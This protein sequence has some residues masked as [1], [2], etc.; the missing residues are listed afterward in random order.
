MQIL[1]YPYNRTRTVLVQFSP[2]IVPTRHTRT[3]LASLPAEPRREAR[4]S[5]TNQAPAVIHYDP[6]IKLGVQRV[7]ETALYRIKS[8]RTRRRVPTQSKNRI[9]HDKWA[10]GRGPNIHESIIDWQLTPPR[11]GRQPI[12]APPSALMEETSN[13]TAQKCAV[14]A[15][16]PTGAPLSPTWRVGWWR[17]QRSH[18][19]SSSL[20]EPKCRTRFLFAMIDCTSRLPAGD[21]LNK[22]AHK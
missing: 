19:S 7:C 14:D 16:H 5:G 18:L 6:I 9:S 20:S 22:S 12:A 1:R 21:G 17:V 13:K 10:N 15:L 2:L 4:A 11:S 8:G 3:H